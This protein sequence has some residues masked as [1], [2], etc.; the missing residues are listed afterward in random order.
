MSTKNIGKYYGMWIRSHPFDIGFA[1]QS[2]LGQL[3]RRDAKPES[4]KKKA[5]YANSDS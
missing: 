3:E 1:T 5:Y 2:A 4:A